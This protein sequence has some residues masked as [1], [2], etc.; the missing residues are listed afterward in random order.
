[1]CQRF[2]FPASFGMMVWVVKGVAL[3]AIRRGD[4]GP[5][6]VEIRTALQGLML[7]PTGE[8]APDPRDPAA[9]VY[10]AACQ[11]AVR[12][13]QQSRGLSADGNVDSDTYRALTEARFRLGDR[14][15]HFAPAHLQRGDD[16]ATLQERLLELGY[17][18]GRIDGIFGPDTNSSLIAFQSDYGLVPD[19]TCGPDT[20]RALSQLGR[21]VTGGSPLRLRE[22]EHAINAGPAL[23][24]KRVVLDAAHGGDDSG[25]VVDGIDEAS[26]AWDIATRTEGRLAVMGAHATLTRGPAGAPSVTERADLAND[27]RADLLI[28]IH[29]T[30]HD[31]TAAQGI[32]TYY[33]GRAQGIGSHIGEEFAGLLNRELTSRTGMVDLDIHPRQFELLRLTRMPAVKIEI[34]YL[35]N[36]ADRAKLVDHAFRDI[37]AEGIVAAVQRFYLS[38]DADVATGT[39]SIPAD[40]RR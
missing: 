2:C 12:H 6:V 23:I 4:R 40:L 8:A 13:F 22:K 36:A 39:W 14:I 25:V 5:A 19:G 18:T 1:M 17:N 7:L 3:Q 16:V 28:S 30:A 29:V 38:E 32:A 9:Q 27:T 20:L 33:F 11:L 31:S 15:L 26:L 37:V 24:G 10:D 35:T 34:G 21:K